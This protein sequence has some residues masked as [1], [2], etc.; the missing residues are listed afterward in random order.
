MKSKIKYEGIVRVRRGLNL[1][2]A[3]LLR[4]PKELHR[5]VKNE[6][7]KNGVTISATLLAIITEALK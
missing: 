6:S 7:K 3:Y 4:M 2:K 5:K 1:E